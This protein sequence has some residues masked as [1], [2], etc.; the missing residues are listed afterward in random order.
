[1][2]RPDLPKQPQ[3]APDDYEGMLQR[4]IA[5]PCAAQE[6]QDALEASAYDEAKAA[7]LLKG[8]RD[9]PAGEF[10][11]WQFQ[12]DQLAPRHQKDVRALV[13]IFDDA[14]DV[15][16]AYTASK[17]DKR[18]AAKLLQDSSGMALEREAAA[19]DDLAPEWKGL[20][21]DEKAAV[22]RL[23]EMAHDAQ[24]ALRTFLENGKDELK[25]S[26]VFA[27]SWQREFDGLSPSEQS[28]VKALE[29]LSEVSRARA[30]EAFLKSGK[31]GRKAAALLLAEGSDNSEEEPAAE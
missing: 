19:F 4:L 12:F 14:E 8:P 2:T 25:A 7:D 20:S 23:V 18:L 3:K 13:T 16:L 15:M 1:M 21:P 26:E 17:G 22:R 9:E 11:K 28:A 5:I 10:G 6:A 24:R 27:P 31:N 29:V 30:V